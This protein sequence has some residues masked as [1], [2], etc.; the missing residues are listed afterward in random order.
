MNWKGLLERHEAYA[1]FEVWIEDSG[2]IRSEKSGRGL[3][4]EDFVNLLLVD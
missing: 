1:T 3:S 4:F 2:A